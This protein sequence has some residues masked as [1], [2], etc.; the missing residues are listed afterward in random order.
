MSITRAGKRWLVP[1]ITPRSFQH[2]HA[3]SEQGTGLLKA[4]AGLGTA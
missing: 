4:A 2:V 1:V 3:P